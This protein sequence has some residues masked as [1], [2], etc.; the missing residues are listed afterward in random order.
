MG[1]NTFAPAVVFISENLVAFKLHNKMPPKAL[2]VSTTLLFLY[3]STQTS[4][5][6]VH[7]HMRV[8]CTVQL[9]DD[10]G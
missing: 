10:E 2:P 4:S 6:V 9:S 1:T 3:A 7:S 8:G 5:C